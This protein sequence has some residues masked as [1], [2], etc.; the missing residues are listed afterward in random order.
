M[1]RSIWLKL[2]QIL[3]SVV[4]KNL[5]YVWGLKFWPLKKKSV[6]NRGSHMQLFYIDMYCF[7][8]VFGQTLPIPVHRWFVVLQIEGQENIQGTLPPSHQKKIVEKALLAFLHQK[9]TEASLLNFCLCAYMP[10]TSLN[11]HTFHSLS[12]LQSSIKAERKI[13]CAT[14]CVRSYRSDKS[15]L[16]I[17]L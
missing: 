1:L 12:E 2:K 10:Q 16:D 14:C 17:K 5:N 11:K 8:R 4:V 6:P 15:T 3:I 9:N 7:R 13:P